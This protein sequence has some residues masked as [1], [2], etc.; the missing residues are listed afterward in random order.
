MTIEL[1]TPK[2]ENLTLVLEPAKFELT[3]GG[4]AFIEPK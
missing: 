1:W 2:L 4:M 3:N